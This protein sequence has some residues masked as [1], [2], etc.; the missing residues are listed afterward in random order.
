MSQIL[1]KKIRFEHKSD[2]IISNTV[3]IK[4]ELHESNLKKT[5]K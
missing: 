4:I 5:Y 3:L 1:T 2:I